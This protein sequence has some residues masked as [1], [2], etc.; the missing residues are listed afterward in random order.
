MRNNRATIIAEAGVN[1]NGSLK[2]AEELVQVAIDSKVDIVKFQTFTAD[3]IVTQSAQKA[4]YQKVTTGSGE[5]QY[6]MLKRLELSHENHFELA[7]LCEGTGVE[8]LS[9]AFDEQ[10]ISFLVNE[11]GIK[12]IKIPSGEITNAPLLL[13]MARFKLPIIMSTGMAT[14]AEIEQ[15]LGV[16]A[17]GL[18]ERGRSKPS[19]AAFLE[20]Y[21]SD[22]GYAALAQHV[23]ILQCTSEYPT[24]AANANLGLMPLLGQVFGLPFGYSDHTE[25]TA[26]SIAARTLG[27]SIIEKHFTLDKNLPGPDHLASLDSRELGELVTGVRSVEAALGGIRK[28]PT[29]NEMQNRVAARRSLVAAQDIGKGEKFSASNLTLKRPGSGASPYLYWQ[30]LDRSSRKELRQDQMI[31]DLDDFL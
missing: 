16:L 9:T 21:A 8:F 23:T 22:E 17:F 20:A 25:G 11:V 10:S 4:E 28:V 6:D 27:A 3:S 14:L 29:K 19:P 1:H 5:S 18:L 24:Q 2:M 13:H 26:V 12:R 31:G 30:F 7:R 15:A